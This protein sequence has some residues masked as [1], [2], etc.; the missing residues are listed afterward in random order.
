MRCYLI[1]VRCLR[2]K[3]CLLLFIIGII[4]LIG[5]V[6]QHKRAA[7]FRSILG[8]TSNDYDFFRPFFSNFSRNQQFVPGSFLNSYV[9]QNISFC[10]FRFG[11]PFNL[12]YEEGDTEYPP[13]QGIDSDYRIIYNVLESS[14][15][16]NLS[17]DVTYC[18]HAT[19]EFLFNLVEILHRWQGPVSITAYVPSTD[20]SLVMCILNRLCS[21]LPD[22]S[23]VSLHFI[24]PKKFPPQLTS[25]LE[26]L[27]EPKDCS[28]PNAV[29]KKA[30]HTF[31][32]SESLTYP[33]NVARNVARRQAQTTFLLVSDV[34]LFPSKNLVVNF[35]KMVTS[36]QKKSGVG[37]EA[38]INKLVYVLPVF[39]VQYNEIIPDVKSKLLQLYAQSQAFYFH[40][41]VCSHC[42]RF[43][44]LQRW[45][46]RKSFVLDNKIEVCT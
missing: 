24:F 37:L 18:T 43:P 15:T 42:Q 38:C 4:F 12:E 11:L 21:C 23:R 27:L 19:P 1:A 28:I 25:C 20:V 16:S 5:R 39:E 17:A 6:F 40:R 32:S 44:G 45:L 9:P 46:L 2:T 33:V 34:E 41:W 22:M 31:R 7:F 35:I 8:R 29:V 30:I 3:S 26:S 10:Q 13:E 36:L 14:F